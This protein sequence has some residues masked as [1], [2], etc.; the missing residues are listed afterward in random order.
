MTP[1]ERVRLWD[2]IN[3]YAQACGGDT[4]SHRT[5]VARQRAVV[6]VERAVSDIEAWW[7]SAL[8]DVADAQRS[9]GPRCS[10]CGDP[11]EDHAGGSREC[12]MCECRAFMA[13]TVAP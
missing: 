11:A 2:A 12:A 13:P 6:A 7:S 4:S 8:R 1:S 10:G 9:V 3:S 5:G